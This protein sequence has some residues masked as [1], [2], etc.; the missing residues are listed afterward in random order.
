MVAEAEANAAADKDAQEL[1]EIKN[2]GENLC[3]Q[4]EKQIR[5]NPTLFSE[6]DKTQIEDKVRALRLAIGADK[7][8]DIQTAY[9]ELESESHRIAEEVYKA[10]QGQPEEGGNPD[11][12][13]TVGAG[14]GAS[15]GEVIDAEFKE[16]EK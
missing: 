12:E 8:D 13:E 14:V 15:D 4:I 6:P 16:D 3:F 9:N 7:K 10:N 1:A 5:D 11:G 2:K